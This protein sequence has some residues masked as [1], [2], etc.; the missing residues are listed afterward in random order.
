MIELSDSEEDQPLAT[1]SNQRNEQAYDYQSHQNQANDNDQPVA[2]PSRTRSQEEEGEIEELV[3]TG[4]DDSS[5]GIDAGHRM[6][7]DQEEAARGRS[8]SSQDSRDHRG[9]A[10]DSEIDS[11]EEGDEDDR[12][13]SPTPP[14]SEVRR[15]KKVRLSSAFPVSMTQKANFD[16]SNEACSLHLE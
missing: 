2:G 15:G 13:R 16:L 7:L 4:S 11:G 6:D 9:F 1:S 14:M 10:N 3:L 12:A 8:R 5:N